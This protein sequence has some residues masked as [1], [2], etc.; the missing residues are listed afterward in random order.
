M[1]LAPQGDIMNN[2]DTIY[3]VCAIDSDIHKELN[4]Y[5]KQC[6]TEN[7]FLTWRKL[8]EKIF[9]HFLDL[10]YPLPLIEQAFK[11]LSCNNSRRTRCLEKTNNIV[12]NNKYV[13]FG[14]LTFNDGTLSKTS[15]KTRRRYVSYYLKSISNDYIANID[16]G[17]K[18]KNPNSN[19]REHYHCLI[20][21]D[22]KP[23][24]W[25]YGFCKF[26]LVGTTEVDCKRISKYIAKLTN[27]SMKVERTGKA[28]RLI[29]S[30][31][32]NIPPFWLFE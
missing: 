30:R 6:F 13:Y 12:S 32:N 22:K 19:E 29:Y 20:A 1:R 8:K 18:T 10:G 3:R 7:P 9:N 23:E 25:K 27:H 24:S 28:K 4:H 14:T 31:T 16:F 21:T 5:K 2:T 11:V 26:Q 17:D 15:D